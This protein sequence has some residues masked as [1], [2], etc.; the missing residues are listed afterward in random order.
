MRAIADEQVFVDIDSQLTQ[1]IHLGYKR[2]WIDNHAVSD[3]ADL[4]VPQDSRRNQMQHIFHA[5]VDDGM[6]CIIAALAANNNVSPRSKDVD[7][8]SFALVA[9]LHSDQNC[10]C[11][12]KSKMGPLASLNEALRAGKKF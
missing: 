4:A 10:V 12:M 8:F 9:P 1:A 2:D 6:P 7:N 5:A 3:H 11:H